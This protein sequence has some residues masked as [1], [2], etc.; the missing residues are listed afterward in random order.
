MGVQGSTLLKTT[1]PLHTYR[2]C[3]FL[4][5]PLLHPFPPKL[6]KYRLAVDF[7]GKC[8]LRWSSEIAQGKLGWTRA[9]GSL[10]NFLVFFTTGYK[11]K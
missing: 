5:L 9:K 4:S 3:P 2:S 1:L 6:E 8:T 10:R 7:V 11:L